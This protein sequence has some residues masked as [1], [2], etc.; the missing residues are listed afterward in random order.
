MEVLPGD[1]GAGIRVEDA[2]SY[3]KG[4][5]VVLALEKAV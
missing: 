2:S 1:G 4:V 3:G 5:L